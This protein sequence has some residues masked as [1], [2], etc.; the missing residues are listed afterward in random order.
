[1]SFSQKFNQTNSLFSPKPQPLSFLL[2]KPTPLCHQFT[3]FSQLS[4]QRTLPKMPPITYTIPKTWFYCT[5]R[6]TFF[7]RHPPF[8]LAHSPTFFFFFCFSLQ[9]SQLGFDSVKSLFL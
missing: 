4:T 6:C 5:S 9:F 3:T 8:F 7:T 1:L 2:F